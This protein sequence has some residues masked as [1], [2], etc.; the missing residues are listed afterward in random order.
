MLTTLYV[1]LQIFLDGLARVFFMYQDYQPDRPRKPRTESHTLITHIHGRRKVSREKRK[2]KSPILQYNKWE[3]PPPPETTTTMILQESP[4]MGH[5]VK[6]P[7]NSPLHTAA[8][9]AEV[10]EIRRALRSLLV[11]MQERDNFGRIV[12]DWRTVALVMDRLFFFVYLVTIIVAL[13]TIFPRS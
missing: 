4:I 6:T 12:Q 10:R 2:I 11:K 13:V 9:E 7:G 1:L 3:P 8:I 5:R